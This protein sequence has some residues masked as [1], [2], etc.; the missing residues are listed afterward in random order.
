ML[1]L[2]WIGAGS[3]KGIVTTTLTDAA[4]GNEKKAERGD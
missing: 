4:G 1:M 2:E 3:A